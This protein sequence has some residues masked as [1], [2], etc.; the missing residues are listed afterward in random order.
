LIVR[1]NICWALCEPVA[2]LSN[3]P[4][5]NEKLP[6]VVGFPVIRPF[7]LRFNPGGSTPDK[8]LKLIGV[9]PPDVSS[10]LLYTCPAVP[11]LSVEGEVIFSDAHCIGIVKSISAFC[12]PD[13]Q[14]SVAL[15]LK[16]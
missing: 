16:A 14:L 7:E 6:A 9:C 15:T 10:W 3:A 13:E 8:R 2:Q 1:L 11:E 4:T 12:A 5:V